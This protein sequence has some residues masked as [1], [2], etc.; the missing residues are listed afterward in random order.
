MK[1]Q[2]YMNLLGGSEHYLSESE[3][4]W[5]LERERK[6]M[7]HHETTPSVVPWNG[8]RVCFESSFSEY[9][10][11]ARLEMN[12]L[13]M[14]G[15]LAIPQVYWASKYLRWLPAFPFCF[16]FLTSFF[17]LIVIKLWKELLGFDL[18]QRIWVFLYW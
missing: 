17:F 15:S 11:G 7:R 12:Q 16:L 14:S 2:H 8:R 5:Y 10:S 4:R 9:I 3:A 6:F 18:N 1:K 13:S